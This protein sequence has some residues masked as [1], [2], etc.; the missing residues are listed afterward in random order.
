VITA[1]TIGNRVSYDRDMGPYMKKTGRRPDYKGG[2]VF[3]TAQEAQ[4]YIDQHGHEWHFEGKVYGLILPTGW[5]EDVSTEP[6]EDGV[7]RL[8][9]DA[10]IVHLPT[11]E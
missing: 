7:H 1:Y 2:W 6:A 3:R 4:A 9:H 10:R 8:L 11:G 5:E